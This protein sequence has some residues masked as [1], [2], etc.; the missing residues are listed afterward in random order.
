MPEIY[1]RTENI[2][3]L[4]F[5]DSEMKTAIKNFTKSGKTIEE[6]EVVL[7]IN[8]IM[9]KQ[10]TDAPN[11]NGDNSAYKIVILSSILIALITELSF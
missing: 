6:N 8:D 5:L 4:S 1:N 2:G 10:N 9:C 11:S 7:M 3:M